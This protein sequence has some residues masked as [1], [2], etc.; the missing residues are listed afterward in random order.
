MDDPF[1]LA[2]AIV[3]HSVAKVVSDVFNATPDMF[4]P[5]A[6]AALRSSTEAAVATMPEEFQSLYHK[7]L[8]NMITTAV[9][10]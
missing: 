2:A 1:E 7:A 10:H 6:L 3:T 9:K 8:D 4:R 5:L